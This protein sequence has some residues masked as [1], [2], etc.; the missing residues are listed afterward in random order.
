MKRNVMMFGPAPGSAGV[1]TTARRRPLRSRVVS[2]ALL[3]AFASGAIVQVSAPNA[4]ASDR[5]DD[6]QSD[7]ESPSS[8][9]AV[10]QWNANAGKAAIAA[11]ISPAPNP[12]HESRMYAMM[13]LA[14]HDALNAIE[15]HSRPYAYKPDERQRDASPDAA[16]ASAARG[17]LVPLLQQLTPPFDNAACIQAAVSG[18]EADYAAAL[19]AIPSG[20]AKTKGI[21]VGQAAAA[22]ILALREGDG[23]DTPLLDF[24]YPQGT[25]PG[26]Y[27]FTSPDTGPF[28][29]AP[30]WA[31][32]TPFVLRDGSQFRPSPPFRINSRQYTQD[33]NEVKR[34]GGDG[35]T[36]PSARTPEQ[37]EIALFWVESSPLAW[38]R[39]TR[40]V[41]AGEHLDLWENARLFGLLN[42]GM[43]DGYIS[44]FDA[45]RFY[46]FWRPITAI[47]LAATDGNSNT[48]ADPKWTPLRETPQI[49]DHDSGHS[50]EG[51][52]AAS[53]L[54]RFFGTDHIA[55]SACSMTLAP[56]ST[57]VGATPV[58]R[59][60]DSFSQAAN[61]NGESRILVGFH[62]RHAVDEGIKHGRKIGDRAFRFLQEVHHDE[63]D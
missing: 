24:N 41:S 29:F 20:T 40:S 5:T 56:G 46:N 16:V 13:H 8:P 12:L 48:A 28:V 34:L 4:A 7:D 17:V 55:F 52:V 42:I 2:A 57:C 25:N 43:A 50:V 47:R 19:A 14:I 10:L 9:D 59:T 37:T 15:L 22:A 21:A 3:L 6:E 27:R 23:S 63:N 53:V 60:F 51:G 45:K 32:V 36:T 58:M 1:A 33:F 44:S 39:L 35:V 49:T 61:E 62:F 54:A 11:C 31:D 38:N 18:V 30:G 26:E